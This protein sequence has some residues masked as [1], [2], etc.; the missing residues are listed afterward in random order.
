MTLP[1][2]QMAFAYYT[3]EAVGSEKPRLHKR[4]RLLTNEAAIANAAREVYNGAEAASALQLLIHKVA[5]A[6]VCHYWQILTDFF[7][8]FCF[9]CFETGHSRFAAERH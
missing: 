3:L 7:V 2:V 9:V 5:F 1:V 6:F 4:L 8:L